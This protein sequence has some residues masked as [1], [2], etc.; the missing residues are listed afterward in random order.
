MARLRDVPIALAKV[1]P[2]TLC[3]RIAG[4][5]AEDDVLTLGAALAYSWLFAL[6]PFMV[7]LL[8]LV[9]LLPEKFKPDIK[10]HIEDMIEGKL[11]EEQVRKVVEEVD[12]LVTRSRDKSVLSMSLVL[13]IW[14]ASAG[15]AR[16]MYAMDKAYDIDKGRAFY[17]RRALAVGLTFV[18][19]TLIVLVLILLP[20][21]TAILKWLV[22]QGDIIPGVYVMVNIGRYFVALFLMFTILAIIYHF[23]PTIRQRFVPLTPGA[24]FCVSVWLLLGWAF[25][26]YLVEFG[27]AENYRN[28]YGAVAGAA[29]L[30]LFFY[31][32]ALVLLI[33]AEINSEINFAVHGVRGVGPVRKKR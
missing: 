23:G 4:Q 18:V 32:D 1:G 25:R 3:K 21:S 15:M 28:T 5:I 33:G 2:W 13:A 16:T 7:F 31:I 20:I 12:F 22:R 26:K 11:T 9:P 14:A 8:T 10:E 24:I 29:I 19:A 27:G 17:R 6:F 30:L